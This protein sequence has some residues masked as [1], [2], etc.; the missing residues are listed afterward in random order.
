MWF[1]LLVEFQFGAIGKIAKSS[2]FNPSQNFY[3]YGIMLFCLCNNYLVM[4]N[5]YH[6][7]T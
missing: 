7:V 2:N 3:S 1:T 6:V 5:S 4:S